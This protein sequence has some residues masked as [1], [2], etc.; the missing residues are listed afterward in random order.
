MNS[1]AAQNKGQGAQ[2]SLQTIM[3]LFIYQHH[4]KRTGILFTQGCEILCWGLL[5]LSNDVYSRHSNV[6]LLLGIIYLYLFIR[7][8][9]MDVL[10]CSKGREDEFDWK[11]LTMRQRTA[12]F[13]A[14]ISMN[15]LF[16]T[17]VLF[18]L[19]F[20]E[21]FLTVILLGLVLPV[22]YKEVYFFFID[23]VL[24]KN[25]KE[26]LNTC[27]YVSLKLLHMYFILLCSMVIWLHRNEGF[28]HKF[29]SNNGIVQYQ[30]P[31][32]DGSGI[33]K[34]DLITH[35]L[36]MSHRKFG[37]DKGRTNKLDP[38][39]AIL[40]EYVTFNC[41]INSSDSNNI[42]FRWMKGAEHISIRA[43][44]R[45]RISKG[46]HRNSLS[47][48]LIWSSNLTI[49]RITTT[50]YDIYTCLART[51]VCKKHRVKE[52]FML[53]IQDRMIC[54]DQVNYKLLL[55]SSVALH[56][57]TGSQH[58]VRAP[59]GYLLRLQNVFPLRFVEKISEITFINDDFN[60]S[61]KLPFQFCSDSVKRLHNLD[62]RKIDQFSE[63]TFCTF[64][65]YGRYLLQAK[66]N[67]GNKLLHPNSLTIL[68]Y[69]DI[70][71]YFHIHSRFLFSKLYKNLISNI[72][73]FSK[74][75]PNAILI[76]TI[77]ELI[78]HH[79][80]VIESHE[81]TLMQLIVAIVLLVEFKIYHFILHLTRRSM[82]LERK[83]IIRVDKRDYDIF[84]SFCEQ[85]QA[86]QAFVVE[87]L[88]PYMENNQNLKI[89]PCHLIQSGSH[90]FE[91]FSEEIQNCKKVVILWS[92]EYA[93]DPECRQ[94][95]SAVILGLHSNELL[96]L[97]DII[98]LRYRSTQLPFRFSF[99]LQEYSADVPDDSDDSLQD[100]NDFIKNSFRK[101]QSVVDKVGNN[102]TFRLCVYIVE[103]FFNFYLSSSG[104]V[105]HFIHAIF[106]I[107]FVCVFI[108]ISSM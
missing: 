45:Y 53:L 28:L 9:N 48:K 8:I 63:T 89:R 83:D 70:S 18:I 79:M 84:L 100:I 95:L 66:F 20:E 102:N 68:P 54:S 30:A 69:T 16:I 67:T 75:N 12:L 57:F 4:M 3:K 55:N 97:S 91:T 92:E 35:I 29:Y 74:D 14:I 2:Y 61:F 38:C 73:S 78:Y 32:L 87:K 77:Q 26:S 44:E 72:T 46:W 82:G 65:Y 49:N 21:M 31:V 103:V 107:C 1:R 10:V 59:L 33:R 6:E 22:L 7:T 90:L 17:P 43:N 52:R 58:V 98:T 27:L 94:I 85:S 51:V 106:A 34:C 39:S 36:P 80:Q 11:R 81:H 13:G 108:W 47:K 76:N 19:T 23:L 37:L 105:Q 101:D 24:V 62:K 15:V 60:K 71:A 96:K 104:K 40:G 56:M 64:L 50:D 99:F 25:S 93:E 88:L 41:R 5:F 86:D 42:V